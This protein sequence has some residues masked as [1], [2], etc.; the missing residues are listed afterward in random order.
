M[1]TP[2]KTKTESTQRRESSG[3]TLESAGPILAAMKAAAQKAA[4]GGKR[5]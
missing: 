2:P 4:G 3:D 1:T 5:H